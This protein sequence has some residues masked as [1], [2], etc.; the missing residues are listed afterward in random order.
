MLKD[1]RLGVAAAAAVIVFVEAAPPVA[2]QGAKSALP[3]PVQAACK[4]V[5][6]CVPSCDGVDVDLDDPVFHP[7]G[8]F[9]GSFSAPGAQETIVSLFPCGESFSRRQVGLTALLKKARS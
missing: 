8:S 6:R 7:V 9:P 4:E 2:G 3:A 1:R 5:K